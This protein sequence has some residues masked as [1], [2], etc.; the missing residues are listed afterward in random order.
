MNKLFLC[1]IELLFRNYIIPNIEVEKLPIRQIHRATAKLYLV[2]LVLALYTITNILLLKLK[3]IDKGHYLIDINNSED[4]YDFR[5][6]EILEIS[7]PQTSANF[8]HLSNV[9]YSLTSL[10]RKSNAIYFETIYYVLRPFLK[11]KR[12]VFMKSDNNFANEVLDV[13]QEYY[14]DSYYIYKI[15]FWILNFLKIKTFL[16]L[17]DSRYSNEINLASRDLNIKTIGYMHGRF[18]EYHLGI[19]EFPFNK[20]LVW[21]N[22]FKNKLLEISNKYNQNDIKV[23]G[24]FRIKEIL[25]EVKNRR[26]ILWLGESNIKYEEIFPY[27]NNTIAN[28]HKVYF[29]GKPGT[30]DNLSNFIQQKNII[31]DDSN[32]FYECLSLNNIGLVIG[33]HSTALMESWIVGVPSLAIKSSYDYGSHLWEDDL[34]ELCE[35]TS[36]NS[37]IDKYSGFSKNK[38]NS[39]RNKIWGKNYFFNENKAIS[40][41][42]ANDYKN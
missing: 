33:T 34:I 4:F 31:L 25:S 28:G 10:H 16:S 37:Y 7:P 32:S 2:H 12:F 22:Y 27:I 35:D 14:N 40:I 17:D 38:L 42:S 20:Y 5:S 18:N 6:K 41:L 21:S 29:R 19:F 26:N 13:Y 3:K 39:V 23:V 11:T 36:L 24:F 30:N 9:R 1:R 15:V 8:M